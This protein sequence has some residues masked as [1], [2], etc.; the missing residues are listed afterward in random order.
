VAGVPA[1]AAQHA[2]AVSANDV[3]RYLLRTLDPPSGRAWHGGPTPVGALR[4]VTAAQARWTPGRGRHSIWELVLHI[5]YWEYAVRRHLEPD[6]PRFPRSPANW[7]AIPSRPDERA[8][9][10]DR[11]LL[12]DE[13]RRLVRALARFPLSRWNRVPPQGKKWTYGELIVGILAHDVYHT[14]QIQLLK[15]LYR[16]RR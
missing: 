3:R 14:G 7:P 16:V 12:A 10:R 5:A 13:H 1:T 8:W 6:G 11:A 2:G 15:R 9:A 4:G